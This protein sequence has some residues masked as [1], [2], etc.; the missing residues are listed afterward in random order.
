DG[1]FSVQV[2]LLID[3]QVAYINTNHEDF[4]GFANAQ[5]RSAQTNKKSIAG[6]QGVQ[7]V[8]SL[9][10]IRKGWLTV[11]NISIIK[12]GAK[13]YWFVLTAESLSWFKDDEVSTESLIWS[14]DETTEAAKALLWMLTSR[15][16]MG[17]VDTVTYRD[18][19][20]DDI[21]LT[22]SQYY[23]CTMFNMI[24]LISVPHTY[25]Q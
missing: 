17:G 20:F 13:E 1:V 9:I 21:V 22:I 2:L 24:Y 16:V 14:D 18:I 19:I 15:V 11:N 6:N 5:Q 23:F 4:I 25:N 7:P 12:G 10:V 3:V 8:S